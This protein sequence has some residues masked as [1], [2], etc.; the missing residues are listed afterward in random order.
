MLQATIA[1]VNRGKNTRA[2]EPKQFMPQWGR[3]RDPQAPM[4]GDDMLRK[5][6]QI[7]KQ[8]GGGG[9]RVDAG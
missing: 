1:N 6:K 8:L 3:A 5:V 4:S 2:Y 7:N 9:E